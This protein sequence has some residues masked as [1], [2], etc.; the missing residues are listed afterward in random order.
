MSS[1]RITGVRI[2]GYAALGAAM[3]SFGLALVLHEAHDTWAAACAVAGLLLVWFAH[4]VIDGPGLRAKP[5]VAGAAAEPARFT[6]FNFATA[7]DEDEE[8]GAPDEDDEADE[9]RPAAMPPAAVKAAGA[10]VAPDQAAPD[11]PPPATPAEEAPAAEPPN[12]LRTLEEVRADMALLRQQVRASRPVAAQPPAVVQPARPP[13]A[14]ADLFARTEVAGLEVSYDAEPDADAPAASDAFART[15]A[16]AL[17][18]HPDN[19]F[20]KTRFER[21]Q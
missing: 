8:D 3:L 18:G 17:A 6:P 5:A 10:P 16:A 13:V 15:E 1:K 11:V 4:R 2:A 19:D 21:P 12:R 7:Q 20:P 9:A 14:V